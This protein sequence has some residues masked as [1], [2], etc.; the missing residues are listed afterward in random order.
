MIF[1]TLL[2][3]DEVDNSWLAS[4]DVSDVNNITFLD[5]IQSQNPGSQS[6]V[7][8]THILPSGYA[9]SSWYKD[10]VVITDVHRPQNLINVGWYD[11]NP[12]QGGG[13]DG[14][15]GV[16]PFLPSGNLVVSDISQGLFVLS[17]TYIRACYLEGMVADSICGQALSGVTITATNGTTTFSDVTG[18][19]GKF[20]TGNVVSGFYTVTFAKAGY[21]T[22]T[23]NNVFIDHGVITNLNINMFSSSGISF[24]GHISDSSL[25][26]IANANIIIENTTNN[27]NFS[28]DVNGDFTRCNLIGGTYNVYAGQWGYKQYCG[29]GISI[30]SST[31][32]D[33]ELAKGYYDDF[34]LNQG[35]TVQTTATTGAW[36]RGVPQ[37]TIF[38][39][40]NA[41]PNTDV[42]NDCSNKAYVTGN[43]GTTSSDDDLDNGYTILTSPVF[44]LTT[45][46]NPSISY[47]RWFFNA[48]G[49]GTPNDSMK[50]ILSNGITSVTLETIIRTTPSNSSWVNKQFRIADFI[51]PTANM[52]LKVRIEDSSPGHLVEGGFDDF[53]IIPGP[54]VTAISKINNS[55]VKLYPNPFDQ[56][57]TLEFAQASSLSIQITDITGREIENIKVADGSTQLNIGTNLSNGVYL[58]KLTQGNTNVLQTIRM[59]KNN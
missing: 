34:T 7:H 1:K 28:S 55:N 25:V 57:T 20:Y 13:F 56:S 29:S 42:S 46:N 50:I 24:N 51:T 9:V 32:Y 8:N 43:T 15:W 33:I 40:I 16:Y 31:T 39:T 45:I 18:I 41:N 22:V 53:E 4:Y 19:D 47:S 2:T 44:D 49:S 35:W 27:Y 36:V 48:G 26:S 37:G 23:R 12:L 54:S 3:T 21:T 10:G 30:N 59:V 6:I 17:P 14:A 5:K 58:I 11:T 38:Q 52:Q